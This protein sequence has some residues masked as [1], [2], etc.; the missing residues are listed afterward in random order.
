MYNAYSVQFILSVTSNSLW[1]HGLQHTRPPCPSPT[2]GDYSNS[3]PLSLWCHPTISSSVVPFSSHLQSFPESGSFPMSQFFTSGGQ[4]TGLSASV[5]VLPMNIHNNAFYSVI[6]NNNNNKEILPLVTRWMKLK[7][8]IL[9]DIS[10]TETNTVWSH[11]FVESQNS[12]KQNSSNSKEKK[13]S[14]LWLPN[15]GHKGK[16]NWMNAVKRCKLLVVR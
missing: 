6:K 1:L 3:C 9:S 7:G 14:D 16:R 4:S 13:S 15:A 8:I 12:K 10:Q 5:S 2:P 11:L